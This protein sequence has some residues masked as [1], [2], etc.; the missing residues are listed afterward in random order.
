M[1]NRYTRILDAGGFVIA[2]VV[3]NRMLRVAFE[4]SV[5][6]TNLH[7]IAACHSLQWS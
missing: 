4:L 2:L 3:V 5:P 6:L 1:A 7:A